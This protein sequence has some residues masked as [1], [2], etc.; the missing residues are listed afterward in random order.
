V[1]ES[2]QHY[3]TEPSTSSGSFVFPCCV[4]ARIAELEAEVATLRKASARGGLG[5][6]KHTGSNDTGMN[7][8]MIKV[9]HVSRICAS[10]EKSMDFYTQVCG[11][12]FLNR[13]NSLAQ[14]TGYGSVMFS[15]TLF[16]EQMQKT[17][18]AMHL[19]LPLVM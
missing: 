7:G 4:N 10:A 13:P 12:T 9:N 17:R 3:Q 11:A 6:S 19:V 2:P 16:K 15:F 18:P 8:L 5:F 1:A 14:D